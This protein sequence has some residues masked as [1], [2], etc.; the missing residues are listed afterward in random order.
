M[1]IRDR[2]LVIISAAGNPEEL[3]FWGDL[4]AK[5]QAAFPLVT[6]RCLAHQQPKNCP[7]ECWVQHW[8]GMMVLQQANVIVGGGGYNTI[9]EAVALG[10]P[11][12]SIP[13]G[14]RYDDQKQRSIRWSYP[15]SNADEAIATLSVLLQTQQREQT[16]QKYIN[17]A[18]SAIPLIEAAQRK[19]QGGRSTLYSDQRLMDEPTTDG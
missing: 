5:I 8:P 12:I 4:T 17:G 2:P 9:F 7:E 3:E 11:L 6:V 14:R 1:C 10:T 15:V 13:H 19:Q 18:D 16:R